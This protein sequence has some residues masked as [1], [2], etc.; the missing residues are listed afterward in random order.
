MISTRQP[1]DQFK[2]SSRLKDKLA[3]LGISVP[4]VLRRAGLPAHFLQQEKIYA[5]TAQFFALWEAIGGIST[6]P[7]VGLAIG[8]EARFERYD[9]MQ[10]AAVC[11]RTFRDAVDRVARCKILTCPEE[12]RVETKGAEDFIQFVFLN[13]RGGEPDILVDTCFSWILAIGERGTNGQIRPVRVELTRGARH[14]DA[15]EARFGCRIRFNAKRN[16]LVIRSADM[17]RPMD[18]YNEELLTIL[19]AQLDSEL[20]A[21]KCASSVGEQVK[22]TLRRTLAG[23]RPSREDVA[24]QLHLSVRTLQRRLSDAGTTFQQV[25]EDTRR[26]LAR[27]YL[28]ERSLELSETA[29]LLG[30]EDSNSFF[31][32]FQTWE[33]TSP[34]EW[35][36]RHGIEPT[37]N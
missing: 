31:R 5:T 30:Y 27:Q 8:T 17:D 19:G 15:L 3:E 28:G 26:E 29:F 25:L 2:V 16:A 10:L 24:R 13:H 33:G 32:A 1:T 11:S 6:D 14:Q 23:R 20:D 35:R 9:P 21:R 37:A 4:A 36:S 7:A 34:G 12:I 22:H 18:T